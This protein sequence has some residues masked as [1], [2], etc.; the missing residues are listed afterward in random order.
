MASGEPSVT[1]HLSWVDYD[2]LVSSV[3]AQ[4]GEWWPECIVGLTRGGLIPAVQLSHMYNTKLYCLNIS[5]RDNKAT[6]EKFDWEQLS[7]YRK[8]LVV[9]DIND[10]GATLK[11]VQEVFHWESGI[12]PKFACLL[13]KMSSESYVDYAGEIINT[14]EENAWI[15][16]PWE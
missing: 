16:F 10:S 13:S 8:V 7:P 2:E 14:L 3:A 9:D 6:A 15:V 5:L 11:K 1:K 4:M 12:S